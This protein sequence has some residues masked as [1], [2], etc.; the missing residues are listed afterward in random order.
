M[1]VNNIITT[2]TPQGKKKGLVE[3]AVY[4]WFFFSPLG[5]GTSS[6]GLRDVCHLEIQTDT[7]P[8]RTFLS[9]KS[10]SV[11]LGKSGER[12][13]EE[14]G[15]GGDRPEPKASD[16]EPRSESR[17]REGG[18]PAARMESQDAPDG[19]EAHRGFIC[20]SFNQDTT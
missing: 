18:N 17:G 13:R 16:L 5:F 3:E 1:E 15:S 4:L 10:V 7:E 6:L 11:A 19:P 14:A 20:A 8:A 12:R 2:A 9:P